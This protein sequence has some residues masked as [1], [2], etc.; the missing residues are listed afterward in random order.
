MGLPGGHC[1][2]GG[3]DTIRSDTEEA[4]ISP[5]DEGWCGEAANADADASDEVA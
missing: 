2:E 3:N 4:E 1:R 5:W